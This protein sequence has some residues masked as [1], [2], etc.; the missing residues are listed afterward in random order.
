MISV[1]YKHYVLLFGWSL[2]AIVITTGAKKAYIRRMEV[3]VGSCLFLVRKQISSVCHR[4]ATLCYCNPD[5]EG[6]VNLSQVSSGG[7]YPMV[8]SKPP[9]TV[10]SQKSTQW[11]QQLK[12]TSSRL[13]NSF[14]CRDLHF[15]WFIFCK[16][17]VKT[18]RNVHPFITFKVKH[19]GWFAII[20]QTCKFINIILSL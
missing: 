3:G 20:T 1:Y 18:A 16:K 19:Q 6:P 4:S 11:L 13:P 8:G 2:V 9:F 10:Y 12:P 17:H 14:L 7:S 15:A 5:D